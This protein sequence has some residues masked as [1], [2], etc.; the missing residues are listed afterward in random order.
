MIWPKWCHDPRQ[1]AVHKWRHHFWRISTVLPSDHPPCIK[2]TLYTL[3]TL[4]VWSKTSRH[5]WIAPNN[6]SRFKQCQR[7][8]LWESSSNHL[9]KSTPTPNSAQQVIVQNLNLQWPGSHQSSL[10]NWLSRRQYKSM[11][12]PGSACN[13]SN[14]EFNF[15]SNPFLSPT[16]I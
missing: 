9:L 14:D 12:Q 6:L 16:N 7:F 4:V 5:L 15:V 8:M 2:S 3:N 11:I 10:K 13:C 1:G